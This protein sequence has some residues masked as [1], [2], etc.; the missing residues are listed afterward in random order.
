MELLLQKKLV[1]SLLPK[2][3]P[4]V[5]YDDLTIVLVKLKQLLEVYY[6]EAFDG[7]DDYLYLLA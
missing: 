2:D 6:T 1:K 3:V 4:I 5:M 7:S